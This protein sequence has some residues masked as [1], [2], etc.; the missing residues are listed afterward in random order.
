MWKGDSRAQR[1]TMG[2]EHL[3]LQEAQNTA[4]SEMKWNRKG[5]SDFSN[6]R[7]FNQA[8]V[9]RIGAA[10]NFPLVANSIHAA[11]R[12]EGVLGDRL[13]KVPQCHCVKFTAALQPQCLCHRHHGNRRRVQ[14]HNGLPFYWISYILVCCE[15]FSTFAAMGFFKLSLTGVSWFFFF[16]PYHYMDRDD[17]TNAQQ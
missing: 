2:Q 5:S 13:H 17:T 14:G 7:K 9:P 8:T 4:A 6:R 10:K 3:R 12:R 11:L 15:V 1:S 16:V